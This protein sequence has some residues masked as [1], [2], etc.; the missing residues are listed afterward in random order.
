MSARLLLIAALAIMLAATT[1]LAGWWT[2]PVVA[3]LWG[4]AR[5]RHRRTALDAGLAAVLAWSALLARQALRG[6][7]D[8]VA[9]KTAAVM[10]LPGP[11]LVLVTLLYAFLLAWSAA[12]LTSSTRRAPSRD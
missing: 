10:G 1:M 7:V 5:F 12:R 9:A 4:A 3:A 6:P 2:L 11:A 8:A